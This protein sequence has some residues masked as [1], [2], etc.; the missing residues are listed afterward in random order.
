MPSLRLI[1]VSLFVAVWSVSCFAGEKAPF[2]LLFSNDTT[3]I[4]GCPSPF[5]PDNGEMCDNFIRAEV[6]EAAGADV[7]MLQPGLGWVPWWKSEILP[8]SDH[9]KWKA[10]Q[11]QKPD[12]F[13]RYVAAGGDMVAVFL[14]ACHEKGSVPFVSLRMNDFHHIMRGGREPDEEERWRRMSEFQRFA[15]HRDLLLGEDADADRL[16][17][18]GFDFGRK[19]VRDYKFAF[20]R[21]IAQRYDI[22][23]LELD[24]MRHPILFHRKK[25]TVEERRQI[26]VDFLRDVR[27]LLDRTSTEEKR[28]WLCVRIPGHAV[29]FDDLGIDLAAWRDAGVDMFNVSASY[30]TT[31]TMDLD[32]FRKELPEDVAFY[33]ELHYVTAVHSQETPPSPSSF[34]RKTIYRRTTPQQYYTAAHV[35]YRRGA[36]GVSLFNFHYYRGTR[37][38]TDVAGIR[39]EP[40]FEIFPKLRD[41]DRLA[42]EPQHYVIA[43]AFYPVGVPKPFERPLNPGGTPERHVLDMAPPKDGWK[44]G[45]RLRIQSS[46]PLK[47]TV[48]KIILNGMILEQTPDVS[49]PFDNPYPEGRGSPEEFQAWNIPSE[50]LKDGIN[51]IEVFLEKSPR[52][53]RIFYL[54]VIVDLVNNPILNRCLFWETNHEKERFY[55]CGTVGGH[56]HHR[57]FNCPASPGRP[58]SEGSGASHAMFES[59]ETDRAGHSQLS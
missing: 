20:L 2:R 23:G 12:K 7:Q 39:M 53:I 41:P 16:G 57:S 1:S 38:P 19:E 33:P 29:K 21:E 44:K 45:G 46:E 15:E 35:A 17:Q 55:S 26:M 14:D 51:H 4:V 11:G 42:L 48:W 37:N 30:F 52:P 6:A 27:S 24:F 3:N 56:C 47:E 59:S 13:E 8:M 34:M 49:E 28:R 50:I 36:S 25:T 54:D 10:D 43:Y 22:A 18:Y 32:R 40:P 5:N 9:L 31:F 58:G